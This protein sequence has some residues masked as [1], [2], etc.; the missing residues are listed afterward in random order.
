M[1]AD[2]VPV[3]WQS[4]PHPEAPEADWLVVVVVDSGEPPEPPPAGALVV[5]V[6]LVGVAV[7]VAGVETAG[8]VA[9]DVL[10]K[11]VVGAVVA[12]VA[13]VDAVD[14]V[15]LLDGD[16]PPQAAIVTAAASAARIR[17]LII[18]TEAHMAVAVP[19]DRG[20]VTR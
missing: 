20:L 8:V 14:V 9:V 12:P 17:S 1:P 4:A 11:V 13:A 16:W 19:A 18:L 3:G 6:E 2:G 10:V 7:V 5:V 15:P